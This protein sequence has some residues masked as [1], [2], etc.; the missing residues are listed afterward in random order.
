MLH[1]QFL[2]IHSEHPEIIVESFDFEKFSGKKAM[3]YWLKVTFSI[4][5]LN[6]CYREMGLEIKLLD[7]VF[8]ADFKNV[9]FEKI[10]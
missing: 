2:E 7:A 3:P 4:K 10:L 9:N 6:F 8:D 5:Y 1:S